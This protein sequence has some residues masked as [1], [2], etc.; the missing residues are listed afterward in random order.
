M[1]IALHAW[2]VQ[3]DI[4]A[5]LNGCQGRGVCRRGFCHCKPGYW[6]KDCSRSVA[7]APHSASSKLNTLKVYVYELPT[8][9]AFEFES[10]VGAGE[11]GRGVG[12]LVA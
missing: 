5:C 8:E 11:P 10:T 9:L 2:C 4:G 6:G 7:Y 12:G 1:L 3:V